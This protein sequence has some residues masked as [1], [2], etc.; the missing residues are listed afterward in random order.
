[1]GKTVF[2]TEKPSVAMEFAKA[3]KINAKRQNGFIENDRYI[4]TWCVGHLVTMSYPECYNKELKKWRMDT[5]PFVPNEWKY[6]VID[7]VKAQ[8]KVVKEIFTRSD[9][10]T[11]YFAGDS[12]REGEYIG[13]LV[14]MMCGPKA[15]KKVLKRVW[16][17]SQTE[18]E[19]LKGIKNAKDLTAYDNLA[20][21]AYL[22]A[23]EDYLMGINFSRIM[24]LKYG[25]SL[26]S[27]LKESKFVI[28]IGRVMTCVLAMVIERE[29]EIRN[30]KKTPFYR[31]NMNADIGSG[32][33]LEWKAVEGSR[34]YGTAALYNEKGFK[35]EKDAKAMAG[36]LSNTA[37][38][39]KITKK[40]E[41]RSAPLLFNLAEL[42]NTCAKM[43][44][45]SPDET[46]QIIQT[47]YEKKLVT[48]P[49]TDA[50]VLTTAVCKE[51]HKNISG[52]A[53]G[54]PALG[55][56]AGQIISNGWFKEIA[57]TKYTNDQMV[58]DHYAVIPTGQG[59][60]ELSRLS[61]LDREVYDVI[62]RRFLAVFLPM[63]EYSNVSIEAAADGEK[64]YVGTK[65]LRNP[66]FLVLYP[67]E[68]NSGNL[69]LFTALDALRKG[70]SV[71]VL[72]YEIK[73]G[74]TKPPNRYNSGSIILAM[75][76]AGQFIDDEALRAQIKGS[77]IGT[78]ATRGETL[79]KL[80]NIGYI[81]LNKKT[82]I[83]TPAKKGYAVYAAS[84]AA[85]PQLLSPKLTA[86]W[87]KGL[88]GVADGSISEDEY[89][90]KLK[91]FIC[92]RTEQIK[93]VNNSTQVRYY[94]R[95]LMS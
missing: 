17:D 66:G 74:E 40:T 77:G 83:I 78:S 89:W 69:A 59:F 80:V 93:C 9:V 85:L 57:N 75:E 58:S 60:S 3:L 11:I 15:Q 34:Y 35:E 65:V 10:D 7:G 12:A 37:V 76:N 30:F 55:D 94:Y 1:M 42:Q 51:I 79:K 67:K 5:L 39:E 31:V 25:T 22:R 18:E 41:K 47:L 81:S 54:Y 84:R 8:F 43:F 29:L 32:I 4:I 70:I 13:R 87:E 72:N 90:D 61:S 48:Y 26:A 19:I 2:L 44:K 21:S 82:Q 28:S 52:I 27:E 68:M 53:S 46:L 6:E 64:F 86:S 16:I 88:D 38:I 49:R 71:K 62:V 95:Q 91:N 23:K 73:E 33:P 45:I 63:A 24:T 20:K 50:R 56:V 92:V 14:L 36:G